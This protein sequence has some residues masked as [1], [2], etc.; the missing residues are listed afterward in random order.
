MHRRFA[1]L[2]SLLALAAPAAAD[3][4]VCGRRG[5]VVERLTEAYGER[6]VGYG[7]QQAEGVVELYASPATGSW[8]I[9]LST[10][11]G[12]ACLLA[13]GRDWTGP[14]PDAAPAA[15]PA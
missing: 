1:A 11:Q 6:R 14:E 5:E 10:P 8:T 13:T 15:D 2:L 12:L 9:I 4:E 3:P 7:L